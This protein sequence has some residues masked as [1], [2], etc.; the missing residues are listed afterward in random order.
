MFI[1][2]HQQILSNICFLSLSVKKTK[3]NEKETANGESESNNFQHQ[4]SVSREIFYWICFYLAYSISVKCYLPSYLFSCIK[5]KFFDTGAWIF[6]ASLACTVL[7][8]SNFFASALDD[9]RLIFVLNIWWHPTPKH[10]TSFFKKRKI[11]K[12]HFTNFICSRCRQI[13]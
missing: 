13:I 11:W 6:D 10:S 1:S 8:A 12:W 4:K 9:D 5:S 2:S 3:K 7:T